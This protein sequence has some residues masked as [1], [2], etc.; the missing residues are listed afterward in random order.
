MS[1]E[2]KS[3]SSS[4]SRRNRRKGK[5]LS[6]NGATTGSPS[7]DPLDWLS[8]SPK[9][10]W[11]A[12]KDEAFAYYHFEMNVDSIDGVCEAYDLQKVSIL[13]TFCMKTGV[14]V[15]QFTD[16]FLS[17]FML[18]I[19]I[20]CRSELDFVWLH[21][22]ASVEGVCTRPEESAVIQWGG[23]HQHLPRG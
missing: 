19:K 11:K 2:L 23:R 14:Q 4:R 17:C 18:N 16:F 21:S 13:R 3:S 22:S 5:Q 20:L 1:D 6:G 12:I 7:S 10:L 8:L 9:S 15:C